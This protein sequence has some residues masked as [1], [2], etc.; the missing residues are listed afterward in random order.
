MNKRKRDDNTGRLGDSQPG[1]EAGFEQEPNRGSERSADGAA[2]SDGGA[3]GE[4]ARDAG[5]FGARGEA[6]RDESPVDLPAS[7]MS[8][9]REAHGAAPGDRAGLRDRV[10]V[11]AEPE[12]RRIEQEAAQGRGRVWFRRRG[13]MVAV[14]A[15]AAASVLLL[16]APF[17]MTPP[18]GPSGGG[19]GDVASATSGER[20]ERDASLESLR[21]SDQSARRERRQDQSPATEAAEAIDPSAR[22]ERSLTAAARSAFSPAEASSATVDAR[23]DLNRDGV[24]DVLDAFLAARAAERPVGDR[25]SEPSAPSVDVNGDGTVDSK[26]VEMIMDAAVKL[27]SAVRRPASETLNGVVRTTTGGVA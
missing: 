11:V 1:N 26:D 12:L 27:S 20:E 4:P 7:M 15:L 24:V 2:R 9:L 22:S 6:G 21:E 5:D 8:A 3:V 13:P 10:M 18:A 19:S 25:A 17:A 23:F 16:V 14:G